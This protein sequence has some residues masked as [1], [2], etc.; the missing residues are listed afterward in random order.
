MSQFLIKLGFKYVRH[1]KT[2]IR[3]KN[4]SFMRNIN[5]VAKKMARNGL[6]IANLLGCAFRFES[7]FT[8]VTVNGV[9]N[10]ICSTDPDSANS[11]KIERTLGVDLGLLFLTCYGRFVNN[12]FFFFTSFYFKSVQKTNFSF[13]KIRFFYNQNTGDVIFYIE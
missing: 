2:T 8:I 9:S 12:T 6:K 5:V 1:I 10:S 7:D 4:L 13:I 3:T 11:A